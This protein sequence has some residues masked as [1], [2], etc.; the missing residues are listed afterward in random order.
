MG[1]CGASLLGLWI[2]PSLTLWSIWGSCKLLPA[3]GCQLLEWK[4]VRTRRR[5]QKQ[6]QEQKQNQSQKRR[7][8]VSDPH[9]PSQLH[10]P[11]AQRVRDYGDGAEAHGNGGEDWAEQQAKEWIQNSGGNGH[12]YR[13]V[14][15]C[16][17][18]IL[19]DVAHGGLA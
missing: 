10:V 7:T 16:E 9:E 1:W 19:T 15:E 12:S 14:D 13:V 18:K 17:E 2:G 3:I 5:K 6:Q 11:Q 8:G 4:R